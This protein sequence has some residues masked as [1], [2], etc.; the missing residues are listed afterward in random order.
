MGYPKKVDFSLVLNCFL[1]TKCGP[2]G[3]QVG[4]SGTKSGPNGTK[5]GPSGGQVGPSGGQVGPS[6]DQV[7]AKWGPSADQVGPSGC[8]VGPSGDA[9]NQ[10]RNKWDQ[11]KL[12]PMGYPKKVDFSLV[13]NGFSE[14]VCSGRPRS[15]RLAGTPC[16]SLKSLLEPFSVP[17]LGKNR[18]CWR[19]RTTRTAKTHPRTPKTPPRRSQDTLKT[20]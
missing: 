11:M 13:L 10:V 1:G 19:P 5:W 15:A 17:L 12:G 3:D 4:P 16:D 6:A 9:W 20:P 8:Q 14:N 18:K 2:N 7:G